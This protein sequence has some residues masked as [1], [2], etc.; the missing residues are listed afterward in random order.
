MPR[1]RSVLAQDRDNY[2]YGVDELFQPVAPGGS[3]V[4]LRWRFPGDEFAVPSAKLRVCCGNHMKIL[5]YIHLCIFCLF[6][7][8]KNLT[9]AAIEIGSI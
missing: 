7:I 2:Y 5:I 1:I 3:V 4:L 6:K 8:K 9:I